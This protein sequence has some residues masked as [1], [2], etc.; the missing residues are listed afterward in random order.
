MVD[1]ALRQERERNRIII[2][3]CRKDCR[4]T[5]PE[6]SQLFIHSVP[7]GIE[8]NGIF[9]E[10]E[11]VMGETNPGVDPSMSRIA[12][13][14]EESTDQCREG[15]TYQCREEN[16]DARDEEAETYF[17][18]DLIE[19]DEILFRNEEGRTVMGDDDEVVICDFDALAIRKGPIYTPYEYVRII[20]SA[21]KKGR[22]YNVHELTTK[23]STI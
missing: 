6:R 4:R 16:N 20:K 18:G 10:G 15:S 1:A 14:P 2:E 17:S 8:G 22:P 21:K 7:V 3:D 12:I 11:N 13:M 23:V 19:D 9:G 5:F